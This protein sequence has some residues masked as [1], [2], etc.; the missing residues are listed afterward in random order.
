MFFGELYANG[1]ALG[2]SLSDYMKLGKRDYNL[3]SGYS[4][5]GGVGWIYNRRFALLLNLE[6]YHI[7]TWKG[8]D[9]D[10]D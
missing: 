2:A 1:V 6:N 10:L 5:K 7:F 4:I 8:Y 9:P 3:G